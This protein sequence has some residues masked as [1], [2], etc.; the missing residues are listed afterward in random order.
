M[1]RQAVHVGEGDT[2]TPHGTTISASANSPFSCT[3]ATFS[4][5]YASNVPGD[6]T[7]TVNCGR[8]SAREGTGCEGRGK[9]T[10]GGGNTYTTG[11]AGGVAGRFWPV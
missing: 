4:V 3:V 11:G 9:L 10:V 6:F 5:T 8:A 2:L 1:L 7:A